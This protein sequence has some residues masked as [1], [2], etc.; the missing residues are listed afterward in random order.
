MTDPAA[1]KELLDGGH[2]VLRRMEQSRKVTIAAV[3]SLALGGGCELAMA[4]DFR[5]AAESASFGQPEINLGIIPGF[6]GTQRLPRLV[7]EAQGARDEPARRPDRRAR[8]ATSSGSRTRWSRTTSCSTRRSPGRASSAARRRSRS[9]RSRTVSAKGD[10]DEGIEAEKGGF[11]TAFGSED[12]REGIARVPRQ[13]QAASCRAS[14]HASA[15]GREPRPGR[16]SRRCPRARGVV[17]LTGP[18][19]SVPSGIPDFRTPGQ[20]AVGEGRPDGGRDDRRLPPRPRR[21]SG[22]S[23]GPASTRWRDKQPNPAH[24]ALA[25]LE[26]RGLLDAVITQNIDRLHRKAGLGAT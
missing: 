13:A 18:G 17:A 3:N 15:R 4:C 10:L 7:G 6:G 22:T 8:G 16:S 14:R 5:I 11:A 9:S 2:G 23:T 24:E 20:R 25:E 19:V 1:G 26:R 21:A 12:A